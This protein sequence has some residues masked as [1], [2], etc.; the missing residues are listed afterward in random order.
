MMRARKAALQNLGAVGAELSFGVP[1]ALR[2][3]LATPG[4][5]DSHP[6]QPIKF[7]LH[8]HV[9]TILFL[10][11]HFGPSRRAIDE[12]AATLERSATSRIQHFLALHCTHCKQWFGSSRNEQLNNMY[13]RRR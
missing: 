7:D 1:P 3:H 2:I 10:C 9:F 4:D 11:A 6:Q 13:L 5:D 12:L 8:C